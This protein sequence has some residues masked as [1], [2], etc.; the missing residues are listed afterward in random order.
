MN[1]GNEHLLLKATLWWALKALTHLNWEIMV[2][3]N[4][5]NQWQIF[6]QLHEKNHRVNDLYKL[7]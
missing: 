3:G 4:L 7:S 1:Q 5:T 6:L 2:I